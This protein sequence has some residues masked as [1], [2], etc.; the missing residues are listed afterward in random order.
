MNHFSS[1][2]RSI[3]TKDDFVA[4][5]GVPTFVQLVLVPEL[6]VMLVKGDMQVDDE[7]AREILQESRDLGELLNEEEDAA[8]RD[9]RDEEE[10]V[11]H[12]N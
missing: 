7:R 2:L 4:V 1:T 11:L 6:T 12:L 8:I 9:T 10:G 5:Q 3:S